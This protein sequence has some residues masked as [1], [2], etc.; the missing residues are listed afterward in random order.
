MNDLLIPVCSHPD[1]KL[2]VLE[3][4]PKRSVRQSNSENLEVR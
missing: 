4:S 2:R 3:K 1:N